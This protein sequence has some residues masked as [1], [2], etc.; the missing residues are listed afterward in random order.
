MASKNPRDGGSAHS[1]VKQLSKVNKMLAADVMTV[2]LQPSVMQSMNVCS[3][4]TGLTIHFWSPSMCQNHWAH[5]LCVHRVPHSCL[6]G[7]ALNKGD[8]QHRSMMPLI[9][10]RVYR[11]C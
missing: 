2:A 11:S 8:Q 9:S 1:V 7:F 4:Q 10:S 5:N 3:H 6:R